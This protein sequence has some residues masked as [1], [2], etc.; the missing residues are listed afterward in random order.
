[1]DFLGH[2][3]AQVR[4]SQVEITSKLPVVRID[5]EVKSL[6]GVEILGMVFF[7]LATRLFKM[8]V[9]EIHENLRH[10]SSIVFGN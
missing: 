8:L 3:S 4:P 7:Q 10:H 5:N 1:M 2:A 9:E 6:L